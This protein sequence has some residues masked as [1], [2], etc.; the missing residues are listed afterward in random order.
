[1]YS[2]QTQKMTKV[3]SGDWSRLGRNA[4]R[5]SILTSSLTTATLK[6]RSS[7]TLLLISLTDKNSTLD[8]K[9]FFVLNNKDFLVFVLTIFALPTVGS[10]WRWTTLWPQPARPETTIKVGCR[11]R[12]RQRPC[13]GKNR[14][15]STCSKSR[16]NRSNDRRTRLFSNSSSSNNSHNVELR[17]PR[18]ARLQDREFG[19]PME[20]PTTELSE[21][22]QG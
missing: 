15:A 21:L 12:R 9:R 3:C 22:D 7:K 16:T 19:L 14:N 10:G 4:G 2:F 17:F 1:M 20:S 13:S 11:R 18:W 6:V 5:S 8:T